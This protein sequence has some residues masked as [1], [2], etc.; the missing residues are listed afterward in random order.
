M[1]RPRPVQCHYYRERVE[2]KERVRAIVR[3]SCDMERGFHR[4][5]LAQLHSTGRR[6][7]SPSARYA[8]VTIQDRE[9]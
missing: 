9:T 6:P 5:G 3:I 4:G 1:R 8:I 7:G 2:P